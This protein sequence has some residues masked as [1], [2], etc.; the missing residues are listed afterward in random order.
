MRKLTPANANTANRHPLLGLL[1]SQL[2]RTLCDPMN[3]NL[4]PQ[5]QV[6]SQYLLMLR[7]GR[8]LSIVSLEHLKTPLTNRI[9]EVE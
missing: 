8:V 3:R 4:T 5:S 7:C 1:F 2:Y 9:W 6:L